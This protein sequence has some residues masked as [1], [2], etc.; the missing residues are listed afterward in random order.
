MSKYAKVMIILFIH[1]SIQGN[2]YGGDIIFN[3]PAGVKNPKE[4]I[5]NF[6]FDKIKKDLKDSIQGVDA[7]SHATCA[8]YKIL[9]NDLRDDFS[10]LL[11]DSGRPVLRMADMSRYSWRSAD[12]NDTLRK[13]PAGK[14]E[15]FWESPEQF[16]QFCRENHIQLIGQFDTAF[17]YDPVTSKR[18]QIYNTPENFEIGVKENIWK[19]KWV[20]DHGYLDLYVAWEVGNE[21]YIRWNSGEQFANYALKLASAVK[22]LDPEIRLA[23][24]LFVCAPDDPNLLRY[25]GNGNRLR[26]QWYR[27]GENMLKSLGDNIEQFYYLNLHLYGASASYNANYKG[28]YIHESF[29]NKF[30]HTKHLRFIIT[31]WRHTGAGDP[32]HRQFKTAALWKAKFMLVMAAYPLVDYTSV[33]DF[34]TWSGVGY[35]SDGKVWFRQENPAVAGE[36]LKC[37]KEVPSLDIGMTAPVLKMGNHIIRNY[38][39]LLVHKADLG[40]KSSVMFA[41]AQGEE[42]TSDSMK[43]VGRDLEWFVC[44]NRTKNKIGALIVNTQDFPVKVTLKEEKNGRVWQ[45][46]KADAL[47]CQP[48][49]VFKFEIPGEKKFWQLATFKANPDGSVNIPPMS[50]VSLEAK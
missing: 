7:E 37:K 46:K 50:V 10:T 35:Y 15:K 49:K 29:M 47:T 26:D 8:N 31:E 38:P 2:M 45:V 19:L 32:K 16:H 25:S 13:Y 41:S 9:L 14:S 27:W 17:T 11:K 6:N 33:H 28:I 22:K 44:S 23:L 3:R 5:L 36:L 48:D 24:T 43:G 34:L 40:E 18:V 42:N 20:I 30:P 21:N 4:R 12:I 1:L 39:L